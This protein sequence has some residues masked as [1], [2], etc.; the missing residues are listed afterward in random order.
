MQKRNAAL[1]STHRG[2]A[3]TP[4]PGPALHR[5]THCVRTRHLVVFPTTP[6]GTAPRPLHPHTLHVEVLGDLLAQHL[7]STRSTHSTGSALEGALPPSLMGPAHSLYVSQRSQLP[8]GWERAPVVPG[9]HP[10]A[11]ACPARPASNSRPLS[12][13]FSTFMARIPPC[14]ASHLQAFSS[15]R[16]VWWHSLHTSAHAAATLVKSISAH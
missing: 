16:R 9:R 12:T 11:T 2:G 7:H 13:P 5:V 3:T 15:Q 1:S 4:L 10:P 14:A 8:A 6:P